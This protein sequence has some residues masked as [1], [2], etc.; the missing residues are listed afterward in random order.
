MLPSQ[1]L[2]EAEPLLVITVLRQRGTATPLL[3]GPSIFR[4]P[5]KERELSAGAKHWEQP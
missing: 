5:P 4:T 3:E 1:V 2:G